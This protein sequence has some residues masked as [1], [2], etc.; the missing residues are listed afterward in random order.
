MFDLFIVIFGMLISS[1]I[2]VLAFFGS[3]TFIDMFFKT[4]L[5]SRV[6]NFIFED[7]E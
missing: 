1:L 6:E 7:E 3:L 5:I 2:L 4:H